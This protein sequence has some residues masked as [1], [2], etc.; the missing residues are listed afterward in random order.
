[1]FLP[2]AFSKQG[3]GVGGIEARIT[4][5]DDDEKLVVHPTADIART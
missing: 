5:L 4:R 1:M 3:T 2:P